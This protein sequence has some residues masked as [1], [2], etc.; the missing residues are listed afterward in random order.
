MDRN[1]DN[2]L[3]EWKERESH[4]PLIIR[5]ARQVGK[6]W[7]VDVFA[8]T[9]THYIKIDFEENRDAISYFRD[10]NIN[11]IIDEITL[12]TGIPI[13]DNKTLLFFDECQL[14]SELLKSL[15]YFFEKRSGLHVIAAGSLL[16]FTLNELQYPMPVGR[17]EFMYMYPL[18]FCEFLSGVGKQNLRNYIER[19]NL[20]EEIPPVT[21]NQL[22]EALRS[23]YF[24]GGM[25]EVVQEYFSSMDLL[26][27]QR[28][29]TAL[30]TSIQ[31]DFLKYANRDELHYLAEAFLYLGR[32]TGKKIKY[33][34]INKNVRSNVVKNAINS[35]VMARI[36]H[37]I[38]H[39]GGDGIPLGAEVKPEHFKTA[40]VDIG[41]SNR[42]CG[43][44]LTNTMDM[45]TIR[46]GLLA[47]QFTA[48]ELIGCFLP[49]EDREMYYW[50]RQNKNANAEVD[51]LI[52]VN[53]RVIPIEVKAGT[54]GSLKSLHVFMASRKASPFAVRF[55]LSSPSVTNTNHK[56]QVGGVNKIVDF[57][58]ISLPLYMISQ[59]KRI[60]REI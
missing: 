14:C 34:N 10:N 5:G 19:Y 28:V 1:I 42:I 58:L 17:V 12:A 13:I 22:L 52:T 16:D 40:F 37:K 23:Y 15:R 38:C 45:L 26:S 39:S 51:Y 11:R 8:K 46:E 27:V 56:I 59:V 53:N 4:K 43:L 9:F 49:F 48:Q 31:H 3:L 35:L 18:T 21:H 44:E 32:N 6:T 29:Q 41:L 50:I 33:S 20:S 25:P 7:S 54:T 55:N 60:T 2:Y 47:E 24:I 30:T 36:S 57:K